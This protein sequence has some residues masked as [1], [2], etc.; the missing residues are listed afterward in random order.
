[1]EPV[2]TEPLLPPVVATSQ[3]AQGLV[4]LWAFIGLLGVLV[5]CLVLLKLYTTLT[6]G[7]CTSTRMMTGKTVIIT[8]SNTGIG[9][10]TAMELARRNARVILACRNMDKARK[11]AEEIRQETGKEVLPK[12][13]DLCSFKSVRKFADDIVATEERLDVLINNA[14]ML[15]P[16]THQV[17]EDGYE[18]TFQANHLGHFLLT[19]LLLD[20]LKKSAPSR[21]VVVGS[22]GHTW[23]WVDCDNLE[24]KD[25]WFPLLNYCSTKVCNML[26]TVELSKRLKGTGVTVN[27][28]H[29]GFVR[30]DFA[31]R[32]SDIQTW[33]FNQVLN[34]YGKNTLQ[35]TQTIL[36]LAISEDV[37]HTS[38]R[39]FSDC[40]PSRPVP[41]ARNSHKAKR[42]YEISEQMT[43]IKNGLGI[44]SSKE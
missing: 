18:V 41:W 3:D 24:F 6:M 35:G 29:P 33:L 17:T 39:Y 1:M 5:L 30:S 40:R 27:C 14:G 28:G 25:Y 10:A 31:A 16:K 44:I 9:K 43:G 23:G 32:R 15:S 38:G 2:T 4:Y 20:M 26:F 8:G 42:L 11:A 22:C 37:A 19:H 21:V 34:V 36:H 12:H 13:L 7:Y